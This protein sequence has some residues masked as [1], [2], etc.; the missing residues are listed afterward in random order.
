ML[1]SKDYP[2]VLIAEPLAF[3]GLPLKLRDILFF[4]INAE[5]K[6]I[7]DTCGV[8]RQALTEEKADIYE[9]LAQLNKQIRAERQK[10][11]LCREIAEATAKM[12][13]DIERSD[14]KTTPER[15]HTYFRN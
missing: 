5:A 15:Q 13:Q 12:Q 7:L 3:Q 8:S 4:G 1:K 6:A 9:Q 2:E 10:I 11:K 14:E